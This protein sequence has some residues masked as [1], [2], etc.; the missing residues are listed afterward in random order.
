MDGYCDDGNNHLD[1]HFDGGDCCGSNVDTLVCTEC[2]CLEGGGGVNLTSTTTTFS[3]NTTSTTNITGTPP[4]TTTNGG[5][6]QWVG[7]GSCDDSNNIEA[8]SFD[9]GDCCGSNVNTIFCTVCQC[10]EG[11]GGGSGGT[12]TAP[13]GTTS[14]VCNQWAGDGFCDDINNNLDCNYDGGDCCGSN[15][16]TLFCTECQCLEGEGGGNLTTTGT[17]GTTVSTGTT[18]TTSTTGTTGTTSTTGPISTTGISL[19]TTTTGVCNQWAGD[20]FCDDINNNLDCNYD[21]GDCCGSNVNT[22]FCTE[23]QCLE[24]E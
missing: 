13:H 6:N 7:D 9:G 8:C 20:G 14:G 12:T 24:G 23:C 15:V 4:S 21:G 11:G 2:Q 1:C 18:G 5:C 17:T 3:N 10:L 16:N 19:D 22:L